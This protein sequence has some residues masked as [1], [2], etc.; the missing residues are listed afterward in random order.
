MLPN[1]RLNILLNEDNDK[2]LILK[3]FK[4]LFGALKWLEGKLKYYLLA[5]T[6]G[7]LYEP[8]I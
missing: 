6:R 1:Q 5:V 2:V 7:I 8:E 3:Y 4:Y